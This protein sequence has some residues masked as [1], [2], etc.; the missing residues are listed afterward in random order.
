M[1]SLGEIRT[2]VAASVAQIIETS[3]TLDNALTPIQEELRSRPATEGEENENMKRKCAALEAR[4]NALETQKAI[5]TE[6]NV[7]LQEK[8]TALE[9]EKATMMARFAE[10]EEKQAKINP[11]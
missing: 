10:Q 6:Q 7:A 8:N 4:Y 3:T 9:G 5:I 11:R 2:I 1:P